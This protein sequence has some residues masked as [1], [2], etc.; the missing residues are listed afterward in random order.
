MKSQNSRTLVDFTWWSVRQV[1]SQNSVC[2]ECQHGGTQIRKEF[3]GR[4]AVIGISS[5]VRA[6]Y[7]G[8]VGPIGWVIES[9]F[10]KLTSENNG[11]HV[12]DDDKKEQDE[13]HGLHGPHHPFH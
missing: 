5:R 2:E 8:R 4:W 12:S 1:I 11:K 9:R 6:V 13:D 3:L 10:S 7:V